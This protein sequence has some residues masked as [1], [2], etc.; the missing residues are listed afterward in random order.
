MFCQREA[1]AFCTSSEAFFSVRL[2]SMATCRA[3]SS[4]STRRVVSASSCAKAG[5]MHPAK[6]RAHN[7]IIHLFLLICLS[8]I[9][10]R[11]QP[12]GRICS[13]FSCPDFRLDINCGD[14]EVMGCH[15]PLWLC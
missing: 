13:P 8:F 3:E 9:S 12:P 2:C 11:R 6:A 15:T 7:A 5:I 10:V 4:D 14:T 1:S